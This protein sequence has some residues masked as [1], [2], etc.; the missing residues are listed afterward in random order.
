MEVSVDPEK[1]L[2]QPCTRCDTGM[3]EAWR[4]DENFGNLVPKPLIIG[5]SHGEER[6][7]YAHR[8]HRPRDQRDE[9]R[10]KKGRKHKR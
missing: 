1:Y 9:K 8:D 10:K 2:D 3:I 5:I 6:S 7:R 4:E